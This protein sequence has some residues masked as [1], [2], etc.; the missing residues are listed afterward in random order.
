MYCW[1]SFEII[2]CNHPPMGIRQ[3]FTLGDSGCLKAILTDFIVRRIGDPRRKSFGITTIN[4]V[5]T[6]VDWGCLNVVWTEFTVGV[7]YCWHSFEI[8]RCHHHHMG[9]L[10]AFMLGDWGCLKAIM[11]DFIVKRMGDTRLK[12][13]GVTTINWVVTLVDWG[14]LKAVRTDFTVGVMCSWHSFEIIRRHNTQL[15]G[16]VSWLRKFESCP[17]WLHCQSGLLLTLI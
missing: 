7:M 9:F 6:L 2:R 11:T 1:H 13:S 14:C 16:Y 5:V 3:A 10:W 12:S 15:G 4:W 17:N 8:I